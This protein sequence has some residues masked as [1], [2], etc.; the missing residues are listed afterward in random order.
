M[1]DS[2]ME[3]RK[4]LFLD[5]DGIINE[6]V[7][8]AHTP[9]QIRFCDGIFDL[10]HVAITKG[11]LLIVITNQA[12]IA[13]GYFSEDAVQS[14]HR[15][16]TEQFASRG[17]VIT[18]FYYC[19]YHAK[20]TVPGYIVDSDCRKPK[21]GMFLQAAA[22]YSIDFSKSLMV[23]DKAS[24]RIQLPELRSVIVKSGYTPETYN[25]ESIRAVIDLL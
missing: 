14:L 20:G 23:G 22:D 1:N 25:V 10:C 7:R 12:G 21:P 4:A 3:K 2:A 15:W 19:P 13:K 9:E 16:I 8:Y 18:A 11:Y 17:I 6:D 24:D 5:R